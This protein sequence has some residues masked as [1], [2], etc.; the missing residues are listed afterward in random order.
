MNNV[1]QPPQSTVNAAIPDIPSTIWQ[2]FADNINLVYYFHALNMPSHVW[3]DLK[4]LDF[5]KEAK[6][7]MVPLYNTPHLSGN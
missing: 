2:T 6:T 1:V 5:K 3:V 7:L 4:Q